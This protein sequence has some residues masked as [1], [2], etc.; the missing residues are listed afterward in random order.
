MFSRRDCIF[1]GRGV[2]LGHFTHLIIY[3]F[4]PSWLFS[5]CESE[6]IGF[7]QAGALEKLRKDFV[8]LHAHGNSSSSVVV[9]TVEWDLLGQQV[10]FLVVGKFALFRVQWSWLIIDVRVFSKFKTSKFVGEC[11]FQL[12]SCASGYGVSGPLG[13]MISNNTTVLNKFF[14][15]VKLIQ[16]S[17]AWNAKCPIFLGNF[18]PKTSNYCLKNRA[19]QE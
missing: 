12:H 1:W 8:L 5:G 9:W 13:T 15:L 6:F 3:G 10:F 11:L 16:K 2:D 17:K 14:F 18:T 19:F 7:P 4:P